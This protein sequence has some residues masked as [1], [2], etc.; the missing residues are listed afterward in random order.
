M[1]LAVPAWVWATLLMIAFVA[2]SA[3]TMWLARYAIRQP[4]HKRNPDDR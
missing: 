3:G 1:L 4:P 2:V